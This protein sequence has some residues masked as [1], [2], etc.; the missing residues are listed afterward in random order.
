M[1]TFPLFEYQRREALRQGYPID[2]VFMNN[3]DLEAFELDRRVC[4]QCK[5]RGPAQNG[6]IYHCNQ[7]GNEWKTIAGLRDDPD[8]YA[9]TLDTGE[10]L[11]WDA[12]TGLWVDS[13][14][15]D[16]YRPET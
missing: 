3:E 8:T 5:N 16:T 1:Y 2:P 14:T 4:S 7:C 6:R 10:R 9:C 13:I 12:H 11:L 15:A